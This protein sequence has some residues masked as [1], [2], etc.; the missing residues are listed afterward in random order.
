MVLNTLTG[1]SGVRYALTRSSTLQSFKDVAMFKTIEDAIRN[2]LSEISDGGIVYPDNAHMLKRMHYVYKCYIESDGDDGTGHYPF[3][4]DTLKNLCNSAKVLI[5]TA[6]DDRGDIDNIIKDLLLA[7]KLAYNERSFAIVSSLWCLK[8]V[9]NTPTY[10][11][12]IVTPIVR[13][14]P[15]DPTFT[16]GLSDSGIYLIKDVLDKKVKNTPYHIELWSFCE[17]NEGHGFQFDLVNDEPIDEAATDIMTEEQLTAKPTNCHI[18]CTKEFR[19]SLRKEKD[20][21][22]CRTVCAEFISRK[23]DAQE[24]PLKLKPRDL[25]DGKNGTTLT[26][27]KKDT[28]LSDLSKEATLTHQKGKPLTEA[29]SDIASALHFELDP[30]G[31]IKLSMREYKDFDSHFK[32]N[33]R[34][35]KQYAKAGNIEGLK[36]ELCKVY[37]MAKLI[38]INHINTRST[39]EPSIRKKM[40]SLRSVMLNSFNHYLGVVMREEP[41][42]DFK[43]HF[44][45]TKY[46]KNLT[47]NISRVG[48]L[49]RNILEVIL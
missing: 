44:D 2:S 7:I 19:S 27:T 21:T 9:F 43:A 13:L 31:N 26:T 42:F 30:N 5:E 49:I 3:H 32:E 36:T 11:E 10:G 25:T 17:V 38:E 8:E 33:T 45:D 12:K 14:V 39:D 41:D 28:S 34:L 40:V 15:K 18:M 1:T 20:S 4:K 46:G 29:A 22:D 6:H 35:M 47:V 16:P 48:K 23:K 37:Y 24:K